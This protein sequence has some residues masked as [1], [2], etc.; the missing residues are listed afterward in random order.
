[1]STP[2]RKARSIAV[3]TGSDRVAEEQM[4]FL[5]EQG[6]QLDKTQDGDHGFRFVSV[7]FIQYQIRT[8]ESHQRLDVVSL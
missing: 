1:M 3:A 4:T 2:E 5:P 7:D 6:G 8:H